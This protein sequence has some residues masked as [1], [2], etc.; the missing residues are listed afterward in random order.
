MQNDSK[1]KAWHS[2]EKWIFFTLAPILA[3]F[4]DQNP[5]MAISQERQDQF[6]KILRCE[7]P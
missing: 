1:G 2:N 7:T 5:K 3:S 6:Q 4:Y